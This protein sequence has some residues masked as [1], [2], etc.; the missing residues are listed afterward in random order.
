MAYTSSELYDQDEYSTGEYEENDTHVPTT[1]AVRA[2]YA[3]DYYMVEV[4]G[5][6]TPVGRALAFDRWLAEQRSKAWEEGLEAAV[7]NTLDEMSGRG[8]PVRENPYST[9]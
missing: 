8:T 3:T 1:E 9:Q 4:G 2:T 5:R 6:G 7:A